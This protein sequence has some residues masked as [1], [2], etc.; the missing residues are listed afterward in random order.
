VKNEFKK[1]LKEK[2]KQDGINEEWMKKHLIIDTITDE[3]IKELIGDK[4]E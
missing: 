1:L 4:D 3:D 2:L